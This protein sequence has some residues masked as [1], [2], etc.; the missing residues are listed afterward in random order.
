MFL[1]VP[2][3]SIAER[4]KMRQ[5]KSRAKYSQ[6]FQDTLEFTDDD[7]FTPNP[8]S[9][10]S[11]K[12]K[13]K[14]VQDPPVTGQGASSA[15]APQTSE[16]TNGPILINARIKVRPRPVKKTPLPPHSPQP[17]P[18]S[19]ATLQN[20]TSSFP[21]PLDH[22]ANSPSHPG[23]PPCSP[24]LN[25]L[26]RNRDIHLPPIE[27][28]PQEGTDTPLPSSLP[29]ENVDEL[30]YRRDQPYIDPSDHLLPPPTFVGSS[31][32]APPVI[33]TSLLPL[34]QPVD[35]ANITSTVTVP[36]AP[37]ANT[38][39]K[40]RNPR[41][42][43][44]KKG[45]VRD[46]GLDAP[47]VNS[48][49]KEKAGIGQVTVEIP[50]PTVDRDQDIVPN[51]RKRRRKQ[52]LDDHMEEDKS[53]IETGQPNPNVYISANHSSPPLESNK[54]QPQGDLVI[55]DPHN[56]T[57]I[58]PPKTKK[59]KGKKCRSDQEIDDDAPSAAISRKKQN[60]LHPVEAEEQEQAFGGLAGPSRRTLARGKK[61]NEEFGK[62]DNVEVLR[63]KGKRRTIITSDDESDGN[64]NPSVEEARAS[65]AD[66]EEHPKING[67]SPSSE[68]S[69]KAAD[70]QDDR[71][72][73][74]VGHLL[75]L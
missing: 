75:L 41:K 54:E 39:T 49:K 25:S 35:M 69:A 10:I 61:C 56:L 68:D 38:K 4:A 36:P 44:K 9:S 55:L 66:P 17:G 42:P 34:S 15:P 8:R 18:I 65:S 13:E 60:I 29:E 3:I 22:L 5:R 59:Y 33:S 46:V 62:D 6:A 70:Q 27:F 20:P 21:S 58:P 19:Q 57:E 51:A 23:L 71:N 1:P 12:V 32:L 63:I 2:S 50:L 7:E 47:Q 48:H 14:A 31:S 37:N 72:V 11:N 67:K 74:K 64:V 26:V 73:L 52:I 43:R 45:E 40:G 24:L 53:N 30:Q 16:P 28:L